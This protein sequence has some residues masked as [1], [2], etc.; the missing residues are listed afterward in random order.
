MTTQNKTQN[1]N[2]TFEFDPATHIGKVNDVL[3]P[4]TTQLIREFRLID[5]SRVTP[6]HLE[7]KRL[8]GIRVGAAT[9]MLDNGTLDEAH[10]NSRFPECVPYL[11]GYRKFRVIENF[12]P[13][14]KEKRYFSTKWRFHGAPDEYGIHLGTFGKDHALIDYKCTWRLYSST[15]P[16]LSS[17]GMLVEECLWIK[18]KKRFGLLLKPT[19]NYELT[20]FKDPRDLSDFQACL[21]LHW[22]RREKYKTVTE[23]QLIKLYMDNRFHDLD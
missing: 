3:W 2:V 8:I 10:F 4:S 13:L 12:E 7:K 17:Y 15:G 5:Y 19:G 11:E 23:E 22:A 18:V 1:N 9:V 21:V 14:Y 20:E 16:Q 6:A